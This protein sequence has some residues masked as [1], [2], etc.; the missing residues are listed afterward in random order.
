MQMTILPDAGKR[1]NG[2]LWVQLID[3]E[4]LAS[5]PLVPSI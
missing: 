5:G 2:R 4:G 3:G 1:L